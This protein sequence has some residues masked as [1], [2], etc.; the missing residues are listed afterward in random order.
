MRPFL[1]YKKLYSAIAP[2]M[3]RYFPKMTT[4]HRRDLDISFQGR[5]KQGDTA[6]KC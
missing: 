5:G 6:I 2:F 4:A 1:C 3:Q